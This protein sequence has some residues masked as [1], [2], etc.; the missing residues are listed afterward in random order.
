MRNLILIPARKNSKRV[1]NKNLVKVL[2]RPLIFWTINY[3]KRFDKKK[4]H[5]VVSSDCAK[6]KQICIKEK[7]TFLKRPKKISNDHAPMRRV[8]LHAMKNLK[9]NYKFI[10]LLQPTSP[11]RK[12]NLVNNSI[13][14][15]NLKKN[16]D[17]LIHLA[18]GASFT[19]TVKNKIW[20]PDFPRNKRSQ[21]IKK[22]YVV[23]G[24][25]YV[26]RASL[27]S[28]NIQFPKKTYPLVSSGEKWIDID[29][30]EDFET[31]NL[32]LK[33]PKTKK[34]LVNSI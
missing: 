15:L 6:I 5:I 26:Y 33:D 11:L 22:K 10:I 21:D 30:K 8:I 27:F 2:N 16:F 4:Y 19:G 31:L 12:I 7:I 32:Y 14:I 24:N 23:S 28:K 9:G 13:K 17:S 29:C 18:K 20:V 34:V 3:A 1:R 25:I